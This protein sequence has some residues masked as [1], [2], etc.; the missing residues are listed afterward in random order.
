M[1]YKEGGGDGEWGEM[2]EYSYN[3]IRFIDVNTSFIHIIHGQE[4][5]KGIQITR[6]TIS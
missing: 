5:E 3:C 1:V 6:M 4:Y 2:S